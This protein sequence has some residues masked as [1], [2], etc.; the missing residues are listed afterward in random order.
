MSGTPTKSAHY[1]GTLPYC[2]QELEGA[3]FIIP[4]V[5]GYIEL[6]E[7]FRVPRLS[8]TQTE[9]FYLAGQAAPWPGL[10]VHGAAFQLKEASNFL[11]RHLSFRR[12]TRVTDPMGYMG[13]DSLGIYDCH[14]YAIDHVSASWGQDEAIDVGVG[15]TGSFAGQV[16]Q[17]VHVY[18]GLDGHNVGALCGNTGSNPPASIEVEW[19]LNIFNNV[20][21]RTPNLSTTGRGHGKVQNNV[22]SNTKNPKRTLDFLK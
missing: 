2:L 11:I 8:G 16:F 20:N 14:D 18:E 13:P 19:N 7:Q 15:V 3:R 4:R 10:E 12:T 22:I 17:H 9:G 6:D 1:T 21:H 5:S